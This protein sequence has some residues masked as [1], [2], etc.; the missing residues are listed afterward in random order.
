MTQHTILGKLFNMEGGY[1]PLV[2]VLH[3]IATP[4]HSPKTVLGLDGTRI[5]SLAASSDKA[6]VTLHVSPKIDP[7]TT[8]YGSKS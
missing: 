7:A 6:E 3:W 4:C 5:A 8:R 1:Y 2:T